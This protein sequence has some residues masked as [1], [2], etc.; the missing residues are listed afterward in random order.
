MQ[1]EYARC[2]R[3]G[4]REGVK[5]ILYKRIE[6]RDHL[7]NWT[8]TVGL[9]LADDPTFIRMVANQAS[10]MLDKHN[11]CQNRSRA[12]IFRRNRSISKPRARRTPRS[13]SQSR[14]F[15][16]RSVSNQNSHVSDNKWKSNLRSHSRSQ[17]QCNNIPDRNHNATTGENGKTAHDPDL[18]AHDPNLQM[19]APDIPKLIN[20]SSPQVNHNADHI[21][22]NVSDSRTPP[23]LT[24]M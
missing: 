21:A 15:Q 3:K 5:K 19:V 9:K 7:L 20:P 6:T 13:R 12:T 23:P 18:N 1:K 24:M 17:S 11:A 10:E 14:T 16:S 22:R 2:I 4:L 8:P